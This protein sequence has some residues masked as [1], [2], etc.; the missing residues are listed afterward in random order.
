LIAG[1]ISFEEWGGQIIYVA[2]GSFLLG[3]LACVALFPV[4]GHPRELSSQSSTDFGQH[5]EA[6]GELLEQTGDRAYAEQ[7]LRTYHEHVRRDS[8]SAPTKATKK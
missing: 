3:F 4:F 5:V 2:N 1:R 6:L 8:G 7:R